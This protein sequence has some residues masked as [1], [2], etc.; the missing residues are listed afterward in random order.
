MN[1]NKKFRIVLPAILAVMLLVLCYSC[2]K[3]RYCYC[4]T[5]ETEMPDTVIW[6]L[7]RG[8]K[9]DHL[10]KLGTEETVTVEGE[11]NQDYTEQVMVVYNYTCFELDR[12]TLSVFDSLNID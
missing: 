2:E 6:N 1:K 3:S 9:C 8:L 12:D 10:M 11:N 7:D 4:T 5:Q